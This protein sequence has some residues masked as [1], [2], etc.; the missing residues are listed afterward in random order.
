MSVWWTLTSEKSHCRQSPR[1]K[2][3]VVPI[4]YLKRQLFEGVPFQSR[5]QAKKS[6][7]DMSLIAFKVHI[8]DTWAGRSQKWNNFSL[9]PFIMLKG[10]D[11]FTTL[12]PLKSIAT[13]NPQLCR[14]WH[15]PCTKSFR[16]VAT[17]QREF[18]LGSPC[19]EL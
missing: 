6:I 19:I 11:R 12:F 3:T 14:L 2:S 9:T 8:G 10:R 4:C 15:V 13:N 7:L 16:Y 18:A 1:N 5:Q 17:T